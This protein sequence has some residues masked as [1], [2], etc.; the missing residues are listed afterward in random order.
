MTPSLCNSKYVY[1]QIFLNQNTCLERASRLSTDCGHGSAVKATL[2]NTSRGKLLTVLSG[3]HGPAQFGFGFMYIY[4]HTYTYT[5]TYTYPASP[6]GDRWFRNMSIKITFLPPPSPGVRSGGSGS[7]ASVHRFL[8]NIQN[9]VR[10]LPKAR[11]C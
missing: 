2:I 4:I 6:L 10:E 1:L 7:L 9:A 5:Y 8:Q 3:Q 11:C